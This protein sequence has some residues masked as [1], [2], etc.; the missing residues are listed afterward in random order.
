[1]S[2]TIDNTLTV[3]AFRQIT[4]PLSDGTQLTA[5]LWL[6]NGPGRVPLVLEWIPYR[7]SDNTAVGDSMTHGYFA[8]HGIAAMRID[9]RGSG[10][11]GGLL[12]DEY[13][14]QE[15]DDAV[16]VIAW[17]AG[18]SWSNGNVGMIGIS[19][20]GFAALQI[21]ARRPPALKAIITCCSTDDRYTDDVHFMGGALLTDG[22]QWGSGL[23][24]QLG[25]PLD[26]AY[27]GD[28]WREQWL[29][30]LEGM[31]PPLAHWL[32]HMERDDYW[33]H[34]SVNENY[35]DIQCAVYAVGGWTD[36]YS[37]AILRLM[38]HLDVPRKGLIG[39]WTHIYPNWGTPGPAIDFLGECLRFWR[40]WLLGEQTGIM[41]EPMLHLWQGEQLRPYPSSLTLD[42]HWI[43]ASQWPATTNHHDFYLGDGLLTDAPA[44][45]APLLIDTPA[46][47]GAMGGEWCP[48]DGG[49]NAPEFQGDQR[50]DDGL[51]V[52]FD[53]PVLEAPLILC[54]KAELTVDIAFETPSAMLVL[55]LNEVDV[56]GHSARVTFGIHRL[57]RPDVP[58]G[59]TF[60]VVLPL[61][62]VVY[63]FSAG[64]RIRLAL[65][66]AYWPM[67][68]AE[69][70]QGP[71]QIL[72]AT[73]RFRL[74]L[75]TESL[76]DKPDA[77]G[78][79]R[80]APALDHEVMAPEVTA[81]RLSW[82]AGSNTHRL[83]MDAQRQKTRIGEL[84]FDSEG[85]EAYEIGA[86]AETASWQ[87]ERR[88]RYQRP[89]WH[90]E[91]RSE[92]RLAWQNGG[93]VL[94][95]SYSAWENDRE[96]FQRQ[97]EHRFPARIKTIGG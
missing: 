85:H 16:E 92:S 3:P 70:G 83:T 20:G 80:S 73:G 13:L 87:A 56:H 1:M 72:P 94:N 4:V 88:Q 65:S 64:C 22:L 55:R 11:S 9:L 60:P 39:P 89:G 82:D 58:A 44:A 26:P 46:H 43:T 2:D 40:H 47:C 36:G 14:S 42:G 18:Q 59:Q 51:S 38:E 27:V 66:T 50:A 93:L 62:G 68:W 54:G 23:F 96:V 32:A 63:R 52:C 61:K 78:P 74:P 34:G 37:D 79:P 53:T 10:N 8:A 31:E 91:L 77:F 41:D 33:R 75:R 24:T 6:P 57:S 76:P 25:R 7:Q 30:R 5:R 17:I 81:R 49:G 69:P 15:Q 19:W 86:T 71:V 21:A 84:S 45:A 95:S 97:W 67:A 28:G 29:A 12:R 90:I 35:R 48:L